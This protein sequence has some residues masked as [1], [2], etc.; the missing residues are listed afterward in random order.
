[1]KP[2]TVHQLLL[3]SYLPVLIWSLI[4]PTDYVIWILEVGPAV[5][6][7]GLLILTYKRFPLT[8]LTYVL[9]WMSAIMMA[10]GGHYTYENVPLFDWIR[11]QFGLTRNHF[12]RLGHFLKGLMLAMLGRELLLRTTPLQPGKWLFVIVLSIPMAIAAG[13]E[14]VEFAAALLTSETTAAEFL[15]WQGDKW[16]AQ[17]DMLYTSSGALVSYLLFS[18]WHDR[19][20]NR[21][22]AEEMLR[23]EKRLTH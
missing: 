2:K 20:L 23:E 4:K 14:L 16:D 1:M 18:R 22:W 15:G 11:D 8:T 10:F 3:Y 21:I 17:W 19:Q 7:I 9:I 5:V 6:G 13:Y 12:D